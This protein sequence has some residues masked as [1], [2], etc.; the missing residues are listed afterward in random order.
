MQTTIP[1]N[2]A[3]RHFGQIAEEAHYLS[4]PFVITRSNKP[5]VAVIGTEVFSRLLELIETYDPGLADT[6]AVTT[7][8][9]IEALLREG[10]AA[11]QKGD[12]EAFDERL[13]A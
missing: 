12:I 9:D 8:P 7:N 2:Q 3:R 13:T 4:C 5:F 11:I 10:D 6:L 1:I